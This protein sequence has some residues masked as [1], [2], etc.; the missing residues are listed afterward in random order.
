MDSGFGPDSPWRSHTLSIVLMMGQQGHT[1]SAYSAKVLENWIST[2]NWRIIFRGIWI[3]PSVLKYVHACDI[4]DRL[5]VYG[6]SL[7]SL[8]CA[9]YSWL[10]NEIFHDNTDITDPTP[11]NRLEAP[12]LVKP[13]WDSLLACDFKNELSGRVSFSHYFKRGCNCTFKFRVVF[14][15]VW[16]DASTWTLAQAR[17]RSC[18]GACSYPRLPDVKNSRIQ[19]HLEYWSVRQAVI[20]NRYWS[21]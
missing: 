10:T 19:P 16:L 9:D 14:R 20:S 2:I 7:S 17:S 5:S 18:T 12:M 1:E 15:V 11:V 6:R 4:C 3:F 8:R 13:S 21:S